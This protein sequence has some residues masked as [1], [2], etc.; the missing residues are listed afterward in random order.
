MHQ[1]TL[2]EIARGLADK[3]FSSEELTR[4][5]LARIAQLDPQLNSF[6]SVTEDLAIAQAQAADTRRAAG[7]TGALLGAPLA[8]KDLFCT[9][10][11][12]TSC[13]SKMLDNFKAPYDATVVARLAAAGAVTLGKTNMDEF[14][15]GSGN[16]SSYYGAV[17]NP[18]NTEHVPGGSSG[19]SAAAVAAR[20]LPVATGTDTG[21]SI[22]QPAAFTNL[23]GLKPTYGRVSRWGM[24]AYASSLDQ[25][26]AFARSAEDC[27]LLLQGMAGFDA[28]DSTSIDEPVP[29]YSAS[30]NGSL[31]G[32]RIG[33]PKEYFGPGLDPRIADLIQASVKELEKLGA[34]IKEI[35]LPNMQHAIPAY[36]V[37]APAEASS[38]LS[39]F[40]GVRFGYR[41]E[42]PAD[43]T[44]LYKRSRAEGFGIEVQRRILVGA[45]AL[46]AG[47]YDA[48]YL[49]AQKIRRLIKNDFMAA[50]QEVDV[51]LG[52]TTPNPAWKIGAKNA[53]PVAEYLED[54]YTITA[55]LAG[56]PG[57]SMPAGFAGGLPVG[58]QL[59]APYFQ[60][61]RLLNVAHRYQQ[62]TDW[63]TRSPEGF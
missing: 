49:Q 16:E 10:G 47:Y 45:Y 42:N 39:R 4:T 48:Y 56:L 9:Q 43:L 53:D 19:G 40:D 2:A 26:G 46:S 55:N 32:L 11:V 44:D 35:S 28:K 5:L 34:V 24:I 33:L 36:Y 57:I 30:L 51:I 52:P 62:V 50:F 21:G 38:N 14:A 8:H 25:A 63:H 54:V 18:W 58:V 31:E 17:K 3:K 13:G 20:L 6:I 41:C 1:L 15:M 60:E 29:D 23:T 61:G 12:R 37:I 59:L 7:E 27:A 22:R